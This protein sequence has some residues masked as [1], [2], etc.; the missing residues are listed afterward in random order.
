M[1]LSDNQ[2]TY[3]LM[4]VNNVHSFSNSPFSIR[5]WSCQPVFFRKVILQ[6]ASNC[7]TWSNFHWQ[8]T[9]QHMAIWIICAHFTIHERKNIETETGAVQVLTLE[10][11]LHYAVKSSNFWYITPC[12]P[13]K[14][15]QH[16]E[17]TCRLHLRG[18]SISQARNL[19]DAKGSKH[20]SA[21]S[22]TLKME[23]IC[24]SEMSV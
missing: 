23:A 20:S 4:S 7:C 18:W 6:S 11:K 9:L 24:S 14:V 12:S 10:L 5:P 3:V 17:G 19:H 15:N 2:E 1:H 13:L 16:S 22:W 8:T 21:Y